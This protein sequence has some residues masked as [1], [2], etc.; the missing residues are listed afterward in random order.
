MGVNLRDY[1]GQLLD[2]KKPTLNV[3]AHT[4]RIRHRDPAVADA[5][6][7]IAD[8]A[9]N[10]S[11]RVEA[12]ALERFG[13]QRFTDPTGKLVA[14][15]GSNGNFHGGAFETLYVGT[16]AINDPANANFVAAADGSL[17]MKNGTFELS[18]NN[19]LS[20]ITNGLFQGSFT[21]F[22]TLDESGGATDGHSAALLPGY[23]VIHPP[24]GG[25]YAVLLYSDPTTDGG[26]LA[27]RDGSG[28]GGQDGFGRKILLEAE[29]GYAV[30]SGGLADANSNELLRFA[31]AANAVNDFAI[32]NAAASGR[33]KLYAS[34]G[35]SDA[36]V[37]VE[38]EG[39]GTGKVNIPSADELTVADTIVPQHF[40]VPLG[41]PAGAAAADYDQLVI[42]PEASEVVSVTERHAGAA[43]SGPTTVMVKKVPSGTALASG[44]D[45]LSAGIDLTAT[46]DTNQSGSLHGTPAN[47]QLAAGDSLGLVT[48]GTLTGVDAVA[49]TVKLKRT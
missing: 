44:T 36:N 46:V 22:Y 15:V 28:S 49:V 30:L 18:L 38:I 1:T 42:V 26:F 43:S 19:I 45:T 20:A 3:R 41:T 34:P 16:D 10:L 24:G 47:Y 7:H 31:G 17:S 12:L 40:Y 48:T 8:Y 13:I 32:T 39:K 27:M 14:W 9:A 35:S 23:L 29:T 37:T 21:G 5:L 2:R 4:A 11:N 25:N 33:P 6:N